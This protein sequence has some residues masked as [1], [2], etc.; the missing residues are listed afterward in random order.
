MSSTL[1]VYEKT[2]TAASLDLTIDQEGVGGVTGKS[3][4]VA[5]REASTV[6]SYLDFS[7]STFK[8]SGWV[9]KYTIM[10]EVERGHYT[11][12]INLSAIGAISVGDVFSVE[13]HVDDGADVV[14]NA[15]DILVVVNSFYDTA[16]DVWEELT[17]NHT[18][19]G[20]FGEALQVGGMTPDQALQLLE[21]YRIHGL[22]P[23]RPLCVSKTARSAGSGLSQT[24][25][26][27]VPTAGTVK[28][29][30]DP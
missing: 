8:T 6:D 30:R 16:G 23:T 9:T 14:G 5:I 24:V 1:L 7:D 11:R 12:N 18:T 19:A 2:D 10:S 21:I 20:T 13:Y 17:A 26:K 15:Q 22:D 4:T 25:E 29:T 27:D 28:V 3:P